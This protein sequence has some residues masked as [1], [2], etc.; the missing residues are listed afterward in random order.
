MFLLF[1]LSSL[2][3]QKWTKPEMQRLVTSLTCCPTLSVLNLSGGQW[4]VETLKTLTEFLPKLDVTK[5][6]IVNDSCSSVEGLVVLTATLS[7]CPAV[8]ELH[9]RLQ[10]P[11]QVSMLFSE[12]RQQPANE[13]SKTLCLSHCG[14]L[15]DDLQKVWKSLGTSSDLTMLE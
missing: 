6:I 13:I 7:D 2:L 4:H 12:G 10:S 11:V 5:K 15:P 8:M 3:N 14:L 9:I 1:F